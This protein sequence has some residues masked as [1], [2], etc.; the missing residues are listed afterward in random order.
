MVVHTGETPARNQITAKDAEDFDELTDPSPGTPM[1]TLLRRFWQPIAAVMDLEPGKAIPVRL[2]CED[3]TLYRGV[4]GEPHVIA[5]RCAHRGTLLH[6]GWVEGETLRCFYH[7]WRYNGEGQCVEQPAENEDFKAK[8][9]ITSYPAREYA[10]L[11]FVYMGE[12]EPPGLPHMVELDRGYGLQWAVGGRMP[13]PCNWLQLFENSVDP[14]HVSFVHRNSRFGDSVSWDVPWLEHE[15][16]E[17]GILQKAWRTPD[18]VRTSEIRFPNCNHIVV[19]QGRKTDPWTDIFVWKVPIDKEH[20]LQISAQQA[21]VEEISVR[22]LE[23]RLASWRAY[24]APDHHDE[25][26]QHI[27]PEDMQNLVGAQDYVAQVGQGTIADRPHERLGQSDQGIILLRKI[28]RRELEAIKKGLPGKQWQPR[29]GFARLS[30]PP[31]FSV[32]PDPEDE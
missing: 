21:P 7:G 11:I 3:L 12:G 31:G 16:T 4:G 25:L 29:K 18:N 17:W 15:E 10:G 14:V 5:Q 1:G 30:V 13:M 9:T 20:T 23:E 28:Y 22:E 24:R 6:T 26:F 2:M 27:W 32:A 19:P 8:V